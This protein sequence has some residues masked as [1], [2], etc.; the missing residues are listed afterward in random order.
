[1]EYPTTLEYKTAYW[2][3][4]DKLF[5]ETNDEA[6]LLKMQDLCAANKFHCLKEYKK[7][8]I[9]LTVLSLQPQEIYWLVFSLNYFLEEVK[10]NRLFWLEQIDKKT[11]S[12]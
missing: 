8:K 3:R 10:K 7:E 1:M 5:I 9:E 4:M 12:V 11:V 6:L 2:S